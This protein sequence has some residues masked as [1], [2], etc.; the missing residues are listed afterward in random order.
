MFDKL[1]TKTSQNTWLLLFTFEQPD[2]FITNHMHGLYSFFSPSSVPPPSMSHP[3]PSSSYSRRRLLS[4]LVFLPLAGLEGG[5]RVPPYARLSSAGR[6]RRRS[7]VKIVRRGCGTDRFGVVV[8]HH[9]VVIAVAQVRWAAARD[10]V[11]DTTQ[12]P[13][14]RFQTGERPRTVA[15]DR[16]VATWIEEIHCL[17]IK[18]SFL[19][20]HYSVVDNLSTLHARRTF[21][22]FRVLDLFL[23]RRS[24]CAEQI[25]CHMPRRTMLAP[26]P[27]NEIWKHMF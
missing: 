14:I 19:L 23:D 8:G 21:V 13:T 9:V 3:T 18:S 5:R 11:L 25:L 7:A 6:R 4:V 24:A 27:A 1:T 26:S 12:W 2:K 10:A 22:H 20:A 17:L 16:L 15:S